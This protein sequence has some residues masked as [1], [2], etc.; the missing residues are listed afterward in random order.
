MVLQRINQAKKALNRAGVPNY[1]GYPATEADTASK[2]CAP[3]SIYAVTQAHITL[4]VEV[5]VPCKQGGA[6]CEDAAC[7]AVRELEKEMA[8]CTVGEMNFDGQIGM[9]SIRI[10][11]QWPRNPGCVVKIEEEEVSRLVSCTAVRTAAM[12]R[13]VDPE[14]G[15]IQQIVGGRLWTVTV[16]DLWPLQEKMLQEQTGAFRLQVIRSGSAETYA[17]C[18]WTKIS[19]EETPAGVLRTR[20]AQTRQERAITAE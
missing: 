7:S 15:E 9:Y 5:F 14:S 4:A 3:V 8:A 12:E 6:A 1:R 10:L 2:S 20:V 19:L 18:V 11:A 17:D 16:V 13:F